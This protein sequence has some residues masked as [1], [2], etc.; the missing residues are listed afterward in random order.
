MGADDAAQLAR[1][2]ESRGMGDAARAVEDAM[3]RESEQD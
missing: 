1:A 3:E 2:L